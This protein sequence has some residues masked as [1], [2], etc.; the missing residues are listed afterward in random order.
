MTRH[1]L[2]SS[3]LGGALLGTTLTLFSPAAIASALGS[4][5]GEQTVTAN[6][7]TTASPTAGTAS[8]TLFP[9]GAVFVKAAD[10]DISMEMALQP[11]KD[12]YTV[13]IQGSQ[14]TSSCNYSGNCTLDGSA[15]SLVCI[16]E[17]D[18]KD[19]PVVIAYHA[20]KKTMEVTTDPG[21]ACGMGATVLGQYALNEKV[22]PLPWDADIAGTYAVMPVEGAEYSGELIMTLES[23]DEY[24]GTSIYKSSFNVFNGA[25]SCSFEGEC[26]LYPLFNR[27]NCSSGSFMDDTYETL[28]GHVNNGV[29]TFDEGNFPLSCGTGVSLLVDYARK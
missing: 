17:S 14:G 25:N 18:G 2:L 12:G 23:T 9:E 4:V 19:N 27:V 3:V 13:L 10:P 5:V 26:V 24:E 21:S 16:N 28:N 8:N 20:A 1:I 7:V 11:E 6:T 15:A 22:K 29:L